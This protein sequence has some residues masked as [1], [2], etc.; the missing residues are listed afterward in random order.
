M[1]AEERLYRST[2]QPSIH[3]A[4]RKGD[5]KQE[6]R[7]SVDAVIG[8]VHKIGILIRDSEQH[9][10]AQGPELPETVFQGFRPAEVG[11]VRF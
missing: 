6:V 1:A 9:F 7:A 4:S 10:T 2:A 8:V 3:T 11:Y 5:P